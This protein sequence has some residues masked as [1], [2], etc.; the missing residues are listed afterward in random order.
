M[1]Y[2]VFGLQISGQTLL[3]I[4][5]DSF[6][7]TLLK[8]FVFAKL[9]CSEMDLKNSASDILKV[10][11]KELDLSGVHLDPLLC[12][13]LGVILEQCDGLSKMDFSHCQLTDESLGHLL[14]HLH[15]A[16]VVK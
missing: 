1:Q 11:G 2:F 8:Q 13:A 3:Y 5:F 10:V 6:D 4:F 9:Q 7:K 16:Q 12:K 15:K 14:P